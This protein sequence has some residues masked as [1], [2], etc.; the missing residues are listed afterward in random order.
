MATLFRI[1]FLL[2]LS[3]FS[4]PSMA[5]LP[6]SLMPNE[7]A[8]A[9]FF[10]ARIAACSAAGRS[11]CRNGY[12][13]EGPSAFK[14]YSA[15]LNTTQVAVIFDTDSN[16]S[17]SAIGYVNSCPTNSIKVLDACECKAGFLQNGATCEPVN[18]CGPGMHEEGG[19]CVPDRCEPSEIR[20]NGVCVPEPP[21]PAGESRVNGKCVPFKC[22]TQ[23]TASDQWYDLEGP[24]KSSTCLYNNQDKTYCTMT[25]TP[26]VVAYKDGKPSYYGGYGVYSG[27]TCG[28]SEPGK[29]TPVDP[30]KPNG[31]PNDGTKPP[32][33][34]DPKPGD[35]PG[36][37]G[38]G[39]GNNPTPP[40]NDGKC[41]EGT[42][43]SGNSCYQK[44]PPKQ[45]PDGDGK[46]PSGYIKSNG[47]CLPLMPKPNDSDGDGK[48]DEDGDKSSFGGQCAATQCD[49]DAI[50][51]AIAREQYRRNCAM[52]DEKTPESELYHASKSKT[53]N[54]TGDLP[55]NTTIAFGADK[56]D[57]TNLLGA[58]S[59]IGD[60]TVGVLGKSVTLEMSRVCPF[61][62]W[63]RLALLAVGAV[64]WVV[65]VFRS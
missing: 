13:A 46:C 51:C 48:D 12:R 34:G 58:G 50:Q 21:C 26:A 31:D 36:G 52:F 15:P 5:S 18:P 25:I 9:D 43:K 11:A 4:A 23:G 63:F 60:V 22:P 2:L 53:G 47:E 40:N 17:V 45:P 33:K 1:A 24:G 30:A 65:I 39:P 8:I 7:P 57:S 32:P 64:L 62:E 28:P 56:Y 44:D 42:Y 61:L 41:P 27:G 29:P 19:A 59:C 14:G 49:G 35:K 20:V 3:V 37:T 6:L 54:Q 55:G 16:W 38:G 10:T